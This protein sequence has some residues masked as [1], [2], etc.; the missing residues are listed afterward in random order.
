MPNSLLC[1]R[2]RAANGKAAARES[3]KERGRKTRG[4]K[5]QW[6]PRPSQLVYSNLPCPKDENEQSRDIFD[7][8]CALFFFCTIVLN[9]TKPEKREESV[10]VSRD[11]I[12]L[13]FKSPLDPPSNVRYYSPPYF[14]HFTKRVFFFMFSLRTYKAAPSFPP[15][16]VTTPLAKRKILI[17]PS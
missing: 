16:Y 11:D 12:V 10:Q 7:C 13:F 15:P 6:H 2:V 8:Y 17:F 1:S 4:E 9:K 14:F 5:K 3:A